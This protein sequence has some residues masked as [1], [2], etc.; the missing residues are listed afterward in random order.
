MDVQTVSLYKTD[1]RLL[2]TQQQQCAFKKII[3]LVKK[4]GKK[5]EVADRCSWQHQESPLG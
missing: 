5:V 4:R 1:H 2:E 3:N